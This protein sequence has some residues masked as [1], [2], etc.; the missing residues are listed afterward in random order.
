M[1]GPVSRLRERITLE[2]RVAVADSFGGQDVA[3]ETLATVFAD[4]QPLSQNMRERSA[5]DQLRAIAGYR[6]T[7]RLRED[8]DA[9]MRLQWQGRVLQIHALHVR[10]QMLELLAYEE[11]L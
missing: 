4:V 8:V 6:V 5:A 1:S 3:W 11:Q 10:E 2:R 9:S 7:L